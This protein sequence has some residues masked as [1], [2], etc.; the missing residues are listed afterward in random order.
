MLKSKRQTRLD[1]V[2][3]AAPPITTDQTSAEL[4]AVIAALQAKRGA[5]EDRMS[6]IGEQRRRMMIAGE[7]DAAVDELRQEHRL[8]EV[9]VDDF[10]AAIRTAERMR[11]T[12]LVKERSHAFE[13]RGE[14]LRSDVLPGLEGDYARF[15]NLG[16]ELASLAEKIAA[17]ESELRGYNT[18]A[19]ERKRHDLR[20]TNHARAKAGGAN[21]NAP[22]KP[23]AR[24]KGETDDAFALRVA[25]EQMR[26]GDKARRGEKF[27]VLGVRL[28]DG[29]GRVAFATTSPRPLRLVE[30]L[31]H[32]RGG[33][34][35]ETIRNAETGSLIAEQP[36]NAQI[37]P[38][39]ENV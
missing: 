30:T 15:L 23:P 26:R 3:A 35:V 7:P 5:A 28:V 18:A 19:I 2:A 14:R 22:L 4:T 36:I 13:Q 10:Q 32:V 25:N 29:I 9:A 27:R 33:E 8:L 21:V 34:Y 11:E 38:E 31:R 1:E 24:M 37:I 12:A 20:I 16:G 39:R 6:Q 17:A